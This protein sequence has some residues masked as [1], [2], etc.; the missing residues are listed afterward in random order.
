MKNIGAEGKDN[1][2]TLERALLILEYLSKRQGAV[3][4]AEI[5]VGLNLNKS[6]AHRLLNIMKD[7][8]FIH[9]EVSTDRYELG[10]KVI[11]I[12][13]SGLLNSNLLDAAAPYLRHLSNV[14]GE[15]SFLAIVDNG[16][17]VYLYKVEGTQSVITNAQLGTRKPIHSTALGK[18]ILSNYSLA[19][20]DKILCDKGMQK[21][22]EK[23]ITDRQTYLAELSKV[24]DIGYAVDDEEAEGGLTCFAHPVFNYT[25]SVMAAV[26][27]AG[28]T[29]RMNQNKEQNVLH[30]K[31]A[32]ENIS[33]RL[34]YVAN[35][36]S[37]QAKF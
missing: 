20:V 4:V 27:I 16:E 2:T 26:S 13:M 23:T 19:E 14:T 17:I 32:V 6:T 22:T 33:K 11:E 10:L 1:L 5:A 36:R 21:F 24:R 31:E 15:T 28:P 35:M 3:G 7:N 8:G 25:G 34:G 9:Q 29:E 18:A 37:R 12:G 30:L